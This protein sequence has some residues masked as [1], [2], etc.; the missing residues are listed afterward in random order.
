[1]EKNGISRP[2]WS[3]QGEPASRKQ[4]IKVKTKQN[5]AIIPWGKQKAA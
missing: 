3:V 4:K 5:R 1:M 2:V